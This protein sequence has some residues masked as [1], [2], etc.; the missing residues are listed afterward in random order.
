[1]DKEKKPQAPAPMA[2][3][4]AQPEAEQQ[5]RPVAEAAKPPATPAAGANP[6]A[7]NKKPANAY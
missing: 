2:P 6:A 7:D 1:M 4:G 3:K 5:R